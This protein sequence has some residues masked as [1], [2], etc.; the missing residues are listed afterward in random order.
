M[1]VP[2]EQCGTLCLPPQGTGQP[3]SRKRYSSGDEALHGQKVPT[4]DAMLG[5]LMSGHMSGVRPT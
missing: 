1:G 4:A 5:R 2:A 3:V